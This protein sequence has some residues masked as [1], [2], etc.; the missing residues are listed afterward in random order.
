M[1]I[2][3]SGSSNKFVLY[4]RSPQS[5]ILTHNSKVAYV[6][7]KNILL[8]EPVIAT[9]SND[10]VMTMAD[11]LAVFHERDVQRHQPPFIRDIKIIYDIRDYH[12]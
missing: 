7:K 3:F 11:M 9:K 5:I 4:P 2:E 10:L 8:H 12:R 6:G 1:G